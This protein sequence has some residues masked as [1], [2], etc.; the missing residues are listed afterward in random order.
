MMRIWGVYGAYMSVNAPYT[1]HIPDLRNA[2]WVSRSGDSPA[3]HHCW[4]V[5]DA[6]IQ[7]ILLNW[8]QWRHSHMRNLFNGTHIIIIYQ[9]HILHY[10]AV[11]KPTVSWTL[12]VITEVQY[13]KN[14]L[15][16]KFYAVSRTTRALSYSNRRVVLLWTH[17]AAGAAVC[18]RE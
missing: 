15:K 4:P 12:G 13:Y 9:P 18:G 16:V 10:N 8:S 11:N 17:I 6:K 3:F 7:W 14:I 1:E 2:V 5:F